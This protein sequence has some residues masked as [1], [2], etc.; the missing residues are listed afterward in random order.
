MA[1]GTEDRID[2]IALGPCEVVS[3]E[4]PIFFEMADNGFDAAA[5]SHFAADG[6]GGDAACVGD[7]DIDAFAFNL[8]AAVAAI[9]VRAFDGGASHLFD[10]VDLPGEAVAVIGI[11][12]QRHGT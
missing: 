6:G 10:L 3:F 5:S 7:G 12:G 1:S 11:S 9:H 4:M 2:G 8:V